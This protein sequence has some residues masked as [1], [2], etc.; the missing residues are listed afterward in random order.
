[1]GWS[2]TRL[3]RPAV[4][5]PATVNLDVCLGDSI[6]TGERSRATIVF[7]DD[8]RLVIDQNT[9]WVVRAPATPG[10]TL[11][12]LVRG[13]ILFFARQ[14]RSLDIR[15]P[16][17]NAA[18]E[19]TEFLVR[20][21]AD[22]T[23][24]TVFEGQV[25]AT[26][27]QGSL[28]LARNESAIAVHGPGS[29][30]TGH[31]SSSGRRAVGAVLRADSAGGLVRALSIKRL[32][33][34]AMP[35]FHV[36]K[37]SDSCWALGRLDE[38]RADLDRALTLDPDDGDAYALRAIIAVALNDQAGALASGREAVRRSPRSAAARLAL[39]YALQANLQ[40]EAARDE[41][42][43]AVADHPDDG[44]AWARLAELWLSLGYL[45]RASEAAKRAAA[46]APGEA[47][48]NT[49][50][51]YA[52]LARI[53]T[54][55]A[56]AA[57]E[58]AISL[59]P[60]NPLARLGLG[61]ARI[62]E[63]HLAEGRRD[64]EIAVAL[65]PDDSIVRSYLGKAYF[66]ERREPLPGSQFERAKELDPHD[67]T[68]WFYDAIRKQTINRPVEALQDLREVHRAERQSGSLP[69]GVCCSTAT[70]R[71]AA[72]ASGESTGTSDSNRRASRPGG[73]R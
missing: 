33:L 29:P 20:V 42:L 64:I 27:P 73:S 37:A 55:A 49:V 10:R 24:I 31:H 43:Q 47:R 9:E 36:R 21:E 38:A 53:D 34:S 12:D 23:L 62:R 57:F 52:A 11:I 72:R 39:S 28:M 68:P 65:N 44:R 59:E 61:L 14:P 5:A 56:R 50:L 19:G 16:F 2:S 58:R 41:L 22:R 25:S 66:D 6:R 7:V 17:V 3:R 4:F 48:A 13:A 40:L 60:D 35:R 8:T 70:W 46:L 67:P 26:N 1:M 30:E 54:S 63:G 69:F 51:G 32:K 15:T 45:D 71:L 18:V